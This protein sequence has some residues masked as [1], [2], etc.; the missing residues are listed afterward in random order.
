M[1]E[2][3]SEDSRDCIDLTEIIGK[4]DWERRQIQRFS[5]ILISVAINIPNMPYSLISIHVGNKREHGIPT[6]K[7]LPSSTLVK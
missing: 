3:V 5:L 1:H 6:S 4:R 2:K 7:N